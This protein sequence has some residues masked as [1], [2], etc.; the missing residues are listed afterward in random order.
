MILRERF[1]SLEKRIFNM[2]PDLFDMS[3][4]VHFYSYPVNILSRKVAP[5]LVKESTCLKLFI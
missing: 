2:L 1:C 3:P 5:R 4:A